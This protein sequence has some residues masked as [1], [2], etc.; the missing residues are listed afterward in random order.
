MV[1]KNN[2]TEVSQLVTTRMLH[3]SEGTRTGE[4]FLSIKKVRPAHPSVKQVP[5]L[6]LGAMCTGCASLTTNGT[7]GTSGAHTC[8]GGTVGTELAP[9]PHSRRL[10][11][12]ETRPIHFVMF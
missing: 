5:G 4:D 1:A 6:V 9:C 7:G 10:H 2:I 3:I 8:S 12:T 11:C